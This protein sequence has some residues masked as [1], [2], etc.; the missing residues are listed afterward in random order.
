MRREIKFFASVGFPY[1]R[2][3]G[4]KEENGGKQKCIRDWKS[5]R[6]PNTLSLSRMQSSSHVPKSQLVLLIL[7]SFKLISCGM[8][9]CSFTSLTGNCRPE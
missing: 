3:E 5:S 7:C 8:R 1:D 4:R 2:E 9:T 6:L